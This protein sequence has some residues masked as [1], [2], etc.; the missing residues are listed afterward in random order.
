MWRS[1]LQFVSLISG[2]QHFN[3]LWP[4]NAADPASNVFGLCT[5]GWAS[6]DL[7]NYGDIHSLTHHLSP[8]RDHPHFQRGSQTQLQLG[9]HFS[10]RWPIDLCFVVASQRWRRWSCVS[11]SQTKFD[12]LEEALDLG[13]PCGSWRRPVQATACNCRPG[14]PTVDFNSSLREYPCAPQ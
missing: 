5:A 9:S 4:V 14:R 6:V 3:V 8:R 13:D 7:C 2:G 1:P 11:L 12:L 10:W